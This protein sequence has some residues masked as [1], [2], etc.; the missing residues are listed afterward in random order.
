MFARTGVPELLNLQ[1]E[2]GQAKRYQIRQVADLIRR[3]DL[4]LEDEG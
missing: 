1:A 2:K 3:Y 4:T